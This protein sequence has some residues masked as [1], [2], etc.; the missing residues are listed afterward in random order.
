MSATR[1]PPWRRA[2]VSI[3]E[4]LVAVTILA[5]LGGPLITNMV[6]ARRSVTA[7]SQ[8]V[9]AVLRAGGVLELLQTVPYDELPVV[10]DGTAS[11][12]PGGLEGLARASWAD[13]FGP[14]SSDPGAP[15]PVDLAA[16]IPQPDGDSTAT[17]YLWIQELTAPGPVEDI[18]TKEITVT[19]AYKALGEAAELVRH[20]TLRTTVVAGR[21]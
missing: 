9:K 20:Y 18:R 5:V 19:V 14:G 2:G 13:S 7:S 3:L 16:R 17:T 10:R 15:P 21:E 4:V 6:F 8:D 1:P 12:L 11:E